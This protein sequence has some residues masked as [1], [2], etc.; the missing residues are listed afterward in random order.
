MRVRTMSWWTRHSPEALRVSKEAAMYTLFEGMTIS[1]SLLKQELR[2]S[3]LRFRRPLSILAP[4]AGR[5]IRPLGR[6]NS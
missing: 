2:P 5:H 4:T 3:L 6:R 1:G